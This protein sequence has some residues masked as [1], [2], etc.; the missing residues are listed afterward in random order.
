MTGLQTLA[1]RLALGV[2]AG[3]AGVVLSSLGSI[4]RPDKAAFRRMATGAFLLT[5][6]GGFVLVFLLFR[7]APRGDVPTYY[8]SEASAVLRGLLPYRDFGSS[9][10]PFHPFLDGGLLFLWHSPLALILFAISV[11]WLLFFLWLRLGGEMF[12]ERD[13][14]IAT[15]L[16]LAS[17]LSL[18]FVAIDGQD[19]VLIAL[20]VLLA[21]WTAMRSR[22]ILSGALTGVGVVAVKLIPIFFAPVFFAGVKRRWGW[23]AGFAAVVAAGYGSFAALRLPILQPLAIEGPLK[24]SGTVP[25]LIETLTGLNLP[26]GLW[27]VVMVL[28]L[29]LVYLAVLRRSSGGDSP[30]SAV[31]V[32]WGVSAAT[33]VMLTFANKSWSPYLLL[34]LFPLCVAVAGR[35]LGARVAFA[36]FGIVALVEKSYWATLLELDGAPEVRAGVLRHD[37]KYIAFLPI[38]VLLLLGYVWL[39]KLCVE[40]LRT[41]GN[42]QNDRGF[43]ERTG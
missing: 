41:F 28:G 40:R 29:G 25:F 36:A 17:A 27:D 8:F 16:Y 24:S 35:G 15:V 9:Y 7:V 19:N 1:A 6:F 31:A 23:A 42:V 38:Q 3:T 2:V 14:R 4:H 20:L 11:E 21:V 22:P 30:S 5:R 43:R 33:L 10:A 18:Q 37:P 26:V 13:L 34:C 32:V 12:P 39:L